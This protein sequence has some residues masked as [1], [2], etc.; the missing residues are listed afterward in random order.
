MMIII[1]TARNFPN[2][3]HCAVK[4]RPNLCQRVRITRS[5]VLQPH[6]NNCFHVCNMHDAVSK[7]AHYTR[8]TDA[9][10]R[11]WNAEQVTEQ[12]L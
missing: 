5:A 11:R 8:S 3:I 9:H 10:R 1:I 2:S 4:F 12:S 6:H 7:L